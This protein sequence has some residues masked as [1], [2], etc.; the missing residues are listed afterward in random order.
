M[1]RAT[2]E[3]LLKNSTQITAGGNEILLPPH[4]IFEYTQQPDKPF[5]YVQSGK[6]ERLERKIKDST[7]ASELRMI[8]F[9]VV[10]RPSKIQNK[11]YQSKS[12]FLKRLDEGDSY[13]QAM[14]RDTKWRH[15][16]A[17]QQIQLV[18]P[19]VGNY[20]Y[21]NWVQLHWKNEADR[22]PIYSTVRDIIDNKEQIMRKYH[23]DKWG[24]LTKEKVIIED[25]PV[26]ITES[27]EILCIPVQ[28]PSQ[29]DEPR[30]G[31]WGM[32]GFGKTMLLHGLVD[33]AIH[34]WDVKCAV[35]NDSQSETGEWCRPDI[36]MGKDYGLPYMLNKLNEQPAGLPSVY[37]TPNTYTT[38]DIM[39]EADGIG[40]KISLPYGEIV[41]NAHYYLDL[42]GSAKYFEAIKDQLITA[43]T[44]EEVGDIFAASLPTPPKPSVVMVRAHMNDLYQKRIIDRWCGV[45]SGWS[46]YRRGR[47]VGKFNPLIACLVAGVTPI[48]ET[49]DLLNK[50]YFAPYFSY[51]ARDLFEK[52]LKD[53][54]FNEH[55][56]RTWVVVDE[57]TDIAKGGKVTMASDQ[58]EL[59]QS[60]GRKRRI[61]TIVAT[62]N[63][64]QVPEKIRTNVRYT[65]CFNTAESDK[66]CYDI[67]LGATGPEANRI[68]KNSDQGGL[69]RYEFM[70]YT[71]DQFVLYDFDGNRSYTQGPVFG[72]L[73]P[74]LSTHSA[75]MRR[76]ADGKVL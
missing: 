73:L 6:E 74:P 12:Y 37:L 71:K 28:T 9:G 69:G 55:Q 21:S 26:M 52:Q 10:S 76:K 65:F 66:I 68:K 59:L 31:I 44:P 46:V 14:P 16:L 29:Q 41:L 38:T 34:H 23:R 43:K 33:R 61:G 13:L 32:T 17:N 70:A 18:G 15:D 1:S 5:F 67:G 3:F 51:F 48:L 62:Q 50:N 45:P 39:H 20:G 57:L 35:C 24:T 8:G 27:N 53:P 42:Q 75:P 36:N 40:Y 72:T 64:S 22:T 47:L 25:L 56:L 4:P 11:R 19:N 63:Y 58:L 60:K 54:Y 7:S 49:S 30:I 2:F